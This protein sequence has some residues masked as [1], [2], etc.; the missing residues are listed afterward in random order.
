MAFHDNDRLR[1]PGGIHTVQVGE[2]RVSHVPDGAVKM[3]PQS[4]FPATS[5][6]TW[7]ENAQYLDASGWLT[8]SAGGLLIE[9]GGRAMLVDCGYGPFPEPVSAMDHGMASMYGGSFLDGLRKLGR[10]P[11]SVEAVALTHLHVEHVGWAAHPEPGA[12]APVLGHADYLL[13]GAEWDGRH[14]TYGV[15]EQV[16][17]ALEPRVKIVADGDEVFP[18]VRAV[19]LPGH[20][21]GQTGYTITSGDA[22]LFA[23][24]DVFHSPVQ[25]AHPDWAIVGEPDADASAR[26]RRRVLEQLA[27]EGTVGF[28]VHFADVPFGRVR[29]VEQDFAWEPLG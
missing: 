26:V 5:Q 15:T 25:V 27:D 21:D 7:E 10:T 11:E 24:A 17:R 16:I 4:L 14:T 18:G 29:R 12:E 6:A 3:V 1:R 13:S 22:R 20:T 9:H 28:G 23:F 2:H 19:A 8:I